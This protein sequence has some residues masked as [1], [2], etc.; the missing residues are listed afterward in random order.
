MLMK[1]IFDPYLVW[2]FDHR[3]M[4]TPL[5][6]RTCWRLKWMVPNRYLDRDIIRTM[7]ARDHP[8]ITSA[9]FFTFSDPPGA[10][11]Q[12]LC[13]RN[14]GT[15]PDW[16]LKA[17]TAN[18]S[19]F[20]PCTGPVSVRD[21]SE[22]RFS[23]KCDI[24]V[25]PNYEFRKVKYVMNLALR[26]GKILPKYFWYKSFAITSPVYAGITCLVGLTTIGAGVVF[27]ISMEVSTELFSVK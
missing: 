17:N 26:I 8:Y 13:W 24:F 16:N 22:I 4:G 5:P 6:P 1:G 10:P 15:P 12:I 18:P 7:Q 21:C 3:H 25:V 14:I 9:H 11:T 27:T 23:Q 2:P 20:W 19:L